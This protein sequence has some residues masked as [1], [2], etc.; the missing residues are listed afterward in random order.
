MLLIKFKKRGKKVYEQS[1]KTISQHSLQRDTAV[2]GWITKLL[3]GIWSHRSPLNGTKVIFWG[4]QSTSLS[5]VVRELFN[6]TNLMCC[7]TSLTPAII[8]T[9]FWYTDTDGKNPDMHATQP[10]KCFLISSHMWRW[11]LPWVTK[12]TVP[13]TMDWTKNLPY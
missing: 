4:K 8:G 7:I 1:Q 9:F 2:Q 6:V 13:F 11:G 12:T 3:K 10:I 5:Y